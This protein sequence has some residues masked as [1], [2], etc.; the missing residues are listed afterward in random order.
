MKMRP[1]HTKIL[2]RR[3]EAEETT[4]GGII[5]TGAKEKINRG[6]VVA[7]G[8]GKILPDGTLQPLILQ[9]GARV[10]FGKYSDQNTIEIDGETLLIMEESDIFGVLEE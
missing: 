2:V 7:V 3:E 9:N 8:T 5:L 4:K 10:I 6:I 1:L